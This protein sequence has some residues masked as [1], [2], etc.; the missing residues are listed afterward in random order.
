M[1]ERLGYL[2]KRKY[3]ALPYLIWMSAFILLPLFFV[4]YY[5]FTDKAGGITLENVFAIFDHLHCKA[6]LL[7]LGLS[8]V[9]TILC[10][11]I[12]FPLALVLR[13]LNM[14]NKGIMIL[15]MVLP[16][17]MNSILRILA[18]QMIL[19]KNGILNMILSWFGIAPLEIINTPAA[20]ILGMVYDFLPYM[21]LPIYN[22][23]MDI[24]GDLIDAAAD[25]GAS[26]RAIIWHVILPLSKP[27]IVSGITMVFIP[28]LT[29]FVIPDI[30]G[31][32][33]IQ[34]LGNVIE[35]EFVTSMNWH[36][37]SGLSLSLLV[38]VIIGLI[39][40]QKQEK[41]DRESLVW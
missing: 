40:T 34:L 27:G 11:L 22:A 8:L 5:A 35:Q 10:L 36:L 18:L 15:I 25:L 29:S 23:V 39:F 19:S 1:K 16:M 38:F 33:K 17:W 32:G 9:C 2:M 24:D 4:A 31:G 21:I 6:T 20:I 14:N 41:K 3:I 13:R 37:G 30:L 7:S 12:S 28:C 26:Y